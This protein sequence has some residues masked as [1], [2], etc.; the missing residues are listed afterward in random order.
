M[1]H[2]LLTVHI[3]AAALVLGALFVQSM[4][5]VM[6]LRLQV[7]AQAE[8]VRTV[9]RRVQAFLYYPMLGVALAAGLAVALQTGAFAAGRWLHWKLVVVVLLIGLGLLIGQFLRSGRAAKG[10][11]LAVHVAV[12]ALG[13]LTVYLASARPF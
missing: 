7:P 12:L 5:V 8:G 11:A 1:Y 13:L 4:L 3:T 10:V 6:A 2:V 9:Q